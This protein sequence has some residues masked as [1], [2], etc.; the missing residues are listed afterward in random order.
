MLRDIKSKL[1]E[2]SEKDDAET[3]ENIVHGIRQ[4]DANNDTKDR[5]QLF[6]GEIQ[7]LKVSFFD[8]QAF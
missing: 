7:D 4:I 5:E 3:T 1:D 8:F 2:S 6:Y